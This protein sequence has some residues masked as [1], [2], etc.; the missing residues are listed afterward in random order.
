MTY[1]LAITIAL[2]AVA[3]AIF[4]Q[5][6]PTPEPM[7]KCSKC[8]ATGNPFLHCTHRTNEENAH[9]RSQWIKTGRRYSDTKHRQ[10]KR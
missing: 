4:L 10:G 9:E 3:T 5:P 8:L 1:A 2:I 6:R 7:K